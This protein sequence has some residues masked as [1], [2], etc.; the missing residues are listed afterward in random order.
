M[1]PLHTSRSLQ[2]DG[3]FKLRAKDEDCASGD[4]ND[5]LQ[6]PSLVAFISFSFIAFFYWYWMIFGAAASANNF[7]FIP[8]WLP[9]VPGWPPTDSDLAP[10]IEDSV[11]FF[12]LSDILNSIEHQVGENQPPALRLGLFNIAEAW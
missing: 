3:S 7:P 11:H 8:D 9:M 6:P 10:A 5:E 4:Q 1:G 12:Y 2:L